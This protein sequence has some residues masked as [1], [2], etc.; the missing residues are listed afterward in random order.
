MTVARGNAGGDDDDDEGTQSAEYDLTIGAVGPQGVQGKLG[1]Q[2]LQGKLGRQGIP[3]LQGEQGKIGNQGV[4]GKRGR[5]VV[6]AFWVVA[7]TAVPLGDRGPAQ[8]VLIGL[9]Q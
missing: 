6:Q 5:Q 7:F 3:G 8:A 2:G 1:D 9:G 4:Q